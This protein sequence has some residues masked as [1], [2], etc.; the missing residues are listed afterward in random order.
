MRLLQNPIL[1]RD[2]VLFLRR[3]RAFLL[4]L[5]YLL[6]LTAVLFAA[7]PEGE[8]IDLG[9]TT[10]S[11]RLVDLILAAQL[12]LLALVTPTFAAGALAGEKERQ[13]YE[14][15]L[16][17]PLTPGTILFGKFASALVYLAVLVFSTLPV[18]MLA[19]PLGGVSVYELAT[20]YGVLLAAAALFAVVGLGCSGWF[21]RTS[22]ALLAAYLILLPIV[23][24]GVGAWFALS[25]TGSLRI[26]VFMI[27][28]PLALVCVG[29]AVFPRLAQRLLHPPDLG[30]EGREV[31]DE[32]AEYEQAVGLVIH[33]DRFPDMLFAPRRRSQLLEDGVNPVFDK[34]LQSE[35][36]GGGTLTT[37][38]V[39]QISM[40]LALPLMGLF[41][42]FQ[43]QWAALYVVYVLTFDLLCAPVFLAGAVTGERERDTLE[44][45]M[46]T[47]LTPWR[48]LWPK[49]L[50]GFRVAIVLTAF[51]L[52]PL[53]LALA[54]VPEFHGNALTFG[55][56]FLIAAAACAGSCS[57]ALFL[58]ILCRRTAT[59]LASTYLVLILKDV[60]PVA[61][62][63]FSRL[64]GD[65]EARLL[66]NSS[67]FYWLGG[68]S[69]FLAALGAPISIGERSAQLSQ[70]PDVFGA[71][72]VWT[73]L[74]NLALVFAAAPL[75]RRRWEQGDGAV[76]AG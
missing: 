51:P 4:L 63:L 40:L 28:A 15:L 22:S 9:D 13:T 8:L 54:L 6:G 52:T 16:A 73:L 3:P 62:W 31:V 47:P 74:L 66:E 17:S 58:S 56:W 75:F 35:I 18:V 24:L 33:R 76:S 59:A 69:P 1:H 19:L 57:I 34:E 2:L 29:G 39:I 10:R 12:V 65:R 21:R 23:L 27:A 26:L 50:T 11:R 48:I 70:P 30:S 25:G 53:L 49:W 64:M 67:W 71:F 37:R 45:L 68:A 20:G 46:T 55:R 36:L 61:V 72:L 43:P 42:F 44:L 32:Q 7:W 60:G 41:L 5:L 38:V 14:M